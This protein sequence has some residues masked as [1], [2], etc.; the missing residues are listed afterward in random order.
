VARFRALSAHAALSRHSSGL[1]ATLPRS[2]EWSG[3]TLNVLMRI[4]AK[5]IAGQQDEAK[6][7][8]LE[9]T[10][11]AQV[12]GEAAGDGEPDTPAE[13]AEADSEQEF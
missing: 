9:A 3:L 2:P 7:R 12:Q 13:E 10:K 4:Y 1:L 6:H 8:I 5:C 11:P